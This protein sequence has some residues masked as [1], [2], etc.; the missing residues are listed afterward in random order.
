NANYIAKRLE[1]HYNLLYS[2]NRGLIAHE[3]II[4]T[5]PFKGSAGIEVEDIAK[6]LID[7]GFHPPTVSFPVPGTL[8]V[9][10][11][12]SESKEELDRYCDAMIAIRQEMKEIE[13]GKAAKGNNLLSNSPHTMADV[14]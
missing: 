13:D 7:F 4:D 1:G 12:E 5:R 14:I 3:C 2:G 8:M 9:E 11:T 10:P 6:R